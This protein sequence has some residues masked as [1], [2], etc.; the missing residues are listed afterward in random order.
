MLYSTVKIAVMSLWFKNPRGGFSLVQYAK[1][2]AI[3]GLKSRD[4]AH[5]LCA[6]CALLLPS[7]MVDSNLAFCKFACPEMCTCTDTRGVFSKVHHEVYTSCYLELVRNVHLYW[8]AMRVFPRWTT[9]WC[10]SCVSCSPRRW[11]FKMCTQ[12]CVSSQSLRGFLFPTT[13]VCDSPFFTLWELHTG[14]LYS[15]ESCTWANSPP[16][17]VIPLLRS[18]AWDYSELKKSKNSKRT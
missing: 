5:L 15:F 8:H 14:Q 17:A 13:M 16:Q 3:F 10:P 2:V 6:M 18:A 9:R 1:A 11:D 7:L 12:L 4:N